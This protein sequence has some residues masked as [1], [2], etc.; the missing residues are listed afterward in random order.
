[1]K[2]SS[3]LRSCSWMASRK[4]KSRTGKRKKK[5]KKYGMK[6]QAVDEEKERSFREEAVK[7]RCGSKG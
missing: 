2:P 5:L 1:M 7:K 4:E 6:S 3:G